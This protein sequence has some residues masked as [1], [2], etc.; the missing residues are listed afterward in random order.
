VPTT[1]LNF[2]EGSGQQKNLRPQIIG[3]K[4]RSSRKSKDVREYRKIGRTIRSNLRGAALS[5][6]I[7]KGGGG[8]QLTDEEEKRNVVHHIER[9]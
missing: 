9:G 4:K 2:L 3:E 8:D 5:K 1:S 7:K 6:P